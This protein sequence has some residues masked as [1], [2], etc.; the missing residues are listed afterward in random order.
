MLEEF[1]K[2]VSNYDLNNERIYSKYTHSLRVMELSCKYAE[3][4]GFN[5]EDIELAT[6]I[7]LLHDFGRFEQL[8]V[9]DSYDDKNT[10]DHAD[11]SVV[12]LF[13][14]NEIEKYTSNKDDYDLIKFAIKNHNKLRIE[15]TNDERKLKFAE[16]IRDVDK[17][18]II[19]VLT[20][21]DVLNLKCTLD[22]VTKQVK[23][24]MFNHVSVNYNDIKNINDRNCVYFSYAFDIN[25]DICLPELK[26]NLK[27]FY[28]KIEGNEKI[29]DIYEDVISY[30]DERIEKNVRN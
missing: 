26:N 15:E 25:N 14:K 22:D 17:I 2:Y 18:D 1:K 10:I 12:Q 30:I 21:T 9:Y 4:L 16:L 19:Y 27:E 6:L 7:G 23:D 13:E 28:I 20:N 11:Y 8:R 5:K 29:K 24:A 3:K